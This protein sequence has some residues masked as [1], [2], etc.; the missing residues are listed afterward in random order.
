MLT[1]FLD[2]ITNSDIAASITVKLIVNKYQ[3]QS[4]IVLKK[5]DY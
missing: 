4:G 2:Y 3:Y 1:K 5:S